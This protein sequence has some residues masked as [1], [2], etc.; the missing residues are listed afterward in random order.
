MFKRASN[1]H[2]TKRFLPLPSLHVEVFNLAEAA[3]GGGTEVEK[4]L[5]FLMT[6]A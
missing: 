6:D 3:G 1:R 5:V 2:E 4:L